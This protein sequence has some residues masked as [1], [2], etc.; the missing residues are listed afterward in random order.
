MRIVRIRNV[1]IIITLAMLF[2]GLAAVFYLS[3]I[4]SKK[5]IREIIE[6]EMVDLASKSIVLNFDNV[7]I[8]LAILAGQPDFD[9][10]FAGDEDAYRNLT[11]LFK[12]YSRKKQIY[13]QIRYIDEKGDEV[14][15]VDL[16][17]GNPVVVNDENLQSK[18]DR[19]YFT[20]SIGLDRGEIYVSP[21]DLNVEH[22]RIEIPFKPVIRFGIAIF[23]NNGGKRGVVMLNYLG[24]RILSDLRKINRKRQ[25]NATLLN[26]DGYWFLSDKPENEWGF[27]LK[28]KPEKRFQSLYPGIWHMI[29]SEKSGQ[30][31]TIDGLF[32]FSTVYPLNDDYYFWKVVS[33]V[34]HEDLSSGGEGILGK[35]VFLCLALA[36]ILAIG[37]WFI[38]RA[39]RHTGSQLPDPISPVNLFII[40]SLVLVTA[41]ALVMLIMPFFESQPKA[42]VAF[43][44]IFFL[45]VMV[46]P[47]LYFLLFKPLSAHIAE[48]KLA[49]LRREEVIGELDKA[50]LELKDFAYI[51]SHDLKAPLRAINSLAGWIAE[52]N[53][54]LL[55]EDGRENLDLLMGRTRRMNNL[56][57][58]ILQFSRVGR[59]KAPK[60]YV[61]GSK[62][63]KDVIDLLHPPETVSIRIDKLPRKIWYNTAQLVMI[64]QNLIGNAIVH[65]GNPDLVIVVSCEE[66][67][68]F[69]RFSVKDNGPGIDRKHHERIFRIFQ[70]L[71]S[72][73]EKEST[74][75]GLALVKKIVDNN[76]GLVSVKSEPGAGSEFLFTIMKNKSKE[77]GVG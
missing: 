1:A 37:S 57:E 44:D 33:H 45:L 42:I 62:T 66:A 24:E 14:I 26:R 16:E 65:G 4:S 40:I 64:F 71:K 58:G 52:D 54:E 53:R 51:V 70:S 10:I 38:D 75:I 35:M 59:D 20:E 60:G 36:L 50:N 5:A 9:H 6:S 41:E 25:G 55:T 30:F 49:E 34:S 12:L 68:G 61:D 46:V 76:G 47:A 22:N 28:G 18:A 19:Y 13:D 7:L 2:C 29:M 31:T 3:E 11:S 43:L 48:R 56:I 15:R 23:D 27:Q 32:T 39:F 21:F 72:R 63:V 73:D 69:Y 74:G 67:S 17:D 77:S 8:D